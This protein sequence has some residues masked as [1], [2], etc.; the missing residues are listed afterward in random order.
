MK[1]LTEKYSTRGRPVAF[2]VLRSGDYLQK[3]DQKALKP[4]IQGH[5]L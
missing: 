4:L 2:K 5:L 3:A 1:T